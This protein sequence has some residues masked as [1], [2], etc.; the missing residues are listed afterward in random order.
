ML[1]AVGRTHPSSALRHRPIISVKASPKAL[2]YA[3]LEPVDGRA[4]WHFT[5]WSR[6]SASHLAGRGAE[7]EEQQQENVAREDVAFTQASNAPPNTSPTLRDLRL[8]AGSRA[9]R[10]YAGHR[11]APWPAPANVG[12]DRT[13]LEMLRCRAQ[14]TNW[15]Q[16][17][18]SYNTLAYRGMLTTKPSR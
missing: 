13:V 2:G 17:S 5:S 1:T 7:G 9:Q 6:Q 11:L 8:S 16:S 4:S 18:A 12:P 10:T 3:D 15:W 14:E